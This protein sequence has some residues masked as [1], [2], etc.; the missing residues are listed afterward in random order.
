MIELAMAAGTLDDALALVGSQIAVLDAADPVNAPMIRHHLEAYEWDFPPGA[1]EAA[2]RASGYAAVCAPAAMFMT[3]AMPV[4]WAP[5]GPP[6]SPLTLAPLAFGRVP[7]PGSTMLATGTSVE[8]HEPMYVGDRLR[9]IWRLV[10][11]TPKQLSIGDGVFLD[12]EI[13]YRKQDGPLQDGPVVAIERTSVFRYD[14]APSAAP[15]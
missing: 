1:D 12:F 6:I 8:F 5:D 10:G 4:Y 13:T 14:P 15:A 9:A 3:F 7:A 2:A 11:V